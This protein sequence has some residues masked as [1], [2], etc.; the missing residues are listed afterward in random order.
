MPVT[1]ADNVHIW[2][3]DDSF[4]ASAEEVTAT[5]SVDYSRNTLTPVSSAGQ[6]L[7]LSHDGRGDARLLG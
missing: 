4:R 3:D 7:A 5:G 6:A 1:T 2:T